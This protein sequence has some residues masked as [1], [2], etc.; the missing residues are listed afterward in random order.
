MNSYL[1]V[2]VKCMEYALSF[3]FYADYK[4]KNTMFSFLIKAHV[5]FLI[6]TYIICYYHSFFIV[7]HSYSISYCDINIQYLFLQSNDIQ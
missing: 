3:I 2:S 5:M 6:V 1:L 4:F 7:T